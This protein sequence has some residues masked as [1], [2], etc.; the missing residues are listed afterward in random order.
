LP[1]KYLEKCSESVLP[2]DIE[3]YHLSKYLLTGFGKMHWPIHLAWAMFGR[4][5][6]AEYK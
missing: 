2:P 4:K 3:V 1:L 5:N 6:L